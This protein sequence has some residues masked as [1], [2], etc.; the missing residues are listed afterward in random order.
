MRKSIATVSLSGMLADKLHAIAATGFD[1]VEIFEND[2]LNFPGTPRDVRALCADLGLR[3]EMFQPFRDFDGVPPDQL[4]R[5]LARAERKFDVMAELGTDLLLVCANIAD[6]ASPDLQLRADQLRLMAERA[7]QRGLR[8]ALEALAWGSAVNRFG[9]VWDIVQRANH[10]QLGITLDSFHTLVLRDDVAPIAAI[11]GDKIFF[12]QLADAPW[13]H[14]DPLTHSRH[15]RCFPG[16]GD[17]DVAG[18]LGAALDAGYSGPISLEIFNDEGK[19]APARE[20]ARDAMRSL[21]WLEEQVRSLPSRRVPG[22][23][24]GLVRGADPAQGLLDPPPEPVLHGWSFIEFAADASTATRLRAFLAT[25]GFEVIGRHRS[26]QVELLGQGDVSIVLNLE[27]D[28][29]AR[30]Y[31]ELHGTSVC[32]VALATEDAEAALARAEALGAARVAGRV[33]PNELTIPAVRAPDGGL[34]YFFDVRNQGSHGFEADFALQTDA[35]DAGLFGPGAR[36]DH[37]SQVLPVGQLDS[38]VLFYRALLGL[39]PQTNTVL[40]DPYGVIKSRALES[41]NLA[42][43]Y[44]LNVSE[45]PGTT[46]GQTVGQFGGAGIQQ[47]AVAVPDIVATVRAAVARGAVMLPISPNYYADLGARY[48]TPQATLDLWQSLGIMCDKAGDGELLHAY[49]VPFEGR[50]FFEI[51]ERRGGYAGY[52]ATD[53]PVR[54]AAQAQWQSRQDDA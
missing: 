8:I 38:W 49:T 52:G 13:I 33:G 16:Q 27:E 35:H 32:A 4:Q 14:T 37:L 24:L 9:Q 53:A 30:S 10:P 29:L 42:V 19:S 1:G 45:R 43:R 47:I 11:P 54:L 26:K 51:I 25:L 23:S 34:L 3:I 46:V 41:S 40:N 7:G 2:L 17:M 48:G 22:S 31:F 20:N 18:F 36:I 6:T 15:Y 39:A 5:N 21:R 28:S 44:A 50:F 12:V